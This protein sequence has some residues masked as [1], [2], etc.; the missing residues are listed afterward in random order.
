MTGSNLLRSAFGEP[1]SPQLSPPQYATALK[2]ARIVVI[3][4]GYAGTTASKYL[5]LFSNHQLQVT[6]I[7]PDAQFVSCPLSNLVIGGSKQ[8]GDIT[9]KYEPLH[10]NHGTQ[11]VKDWV[12]SIDPVAR[13][14]KTSSGL[15]FPYDE[16]ILCPGVE[17]M[18]SSIAG[19]QEA[20]TQG[21]ILQAWSAGDETL[22]LR[23]QLESM[24]DGEVFAITVPELPYR[25]PPGPYERASQVAY[26]FKHFKPKS[27]VIILDANQD[28]TSKGPLFKKFWRENY[29]NH[30]EYRPEH[31]VLEVD[32]RSKTLKFE[33]QD[34]LQAGVLN[35]LPPMRAGAIAVQTGL[36]NI[37][38]RWC[39]V[40]FLS[41]E[42]TVAAHIHVLGD[43]IQA[44]PYM[45][46]SAHM[47]NAHA[48]VAAAAVVAKLCEF[49]INPQPFLTNT[50]YS[51]VDPEQAIYIASVHQYD[52]GERTFKILPNAGG[53]SGD[54]SKQEGNNALGWAKNIW[55][56]CLT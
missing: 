52:T 36:A 19:L 4:G 27:K 26:Y 11:I 3:G 22:K 21:S 2:K 35:V 17:L 30:L 20:K 16:L 45:P 1:I 31:K 9:F 28:I 41:F 50:C 47:A 32:A 14:V 7:E 23:L 8:M 39:E 37:N 42:S 33:I 18:Y 25:C 24:Q 44:G 12:S 34:D 40:N 5:G 29:P 15:V 51:F 54:A 53:M 13:K 38:K 46:K 43:S 55:A 6:L 49:Q 56:D 48:K 10:K